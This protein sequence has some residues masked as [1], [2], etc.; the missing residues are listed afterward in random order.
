MASPA[1]IPLAQLVAALSGA[2]DLTEGSPV[3]HS[4][5]AAAGRAAGFNAIAQQELYR[6]GLLHDLG[7][8][9]VPNTILDKPGRLT[10]SEW[11]IMREHPAG[12]ARILAPI[13]AL[14]GVTAIAVAHHERMDGAG[15]H[16]GIPAGQLPFAARLLAAADIYEA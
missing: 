9:G 15:Y 5:A 12:T 4:G 8:L 16:Q 3:G 2:L 11:A 14:A 7:K 13:P 1:V 10:P 6:A